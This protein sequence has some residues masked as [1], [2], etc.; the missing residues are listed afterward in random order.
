MGESEKR[1]V[2]DITDLKA[3][4]RDAQ[5]T[6][7][8]EAADIHIILEPGITPNVIRALLGDIEGTKFL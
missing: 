7:K 1:M 8:S 3:L 4:M 5:I 2:L 6:L